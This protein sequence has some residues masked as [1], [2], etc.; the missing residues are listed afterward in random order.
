MSVEEAIKILTNLDVFKCD[1][2]NCK[3]YND[4]N[5]NKYCPDCP[6]RKY[7]EALKILITSYYKLFF[8]YNKED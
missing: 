8:M 6:M 3:Y 7:D 5:A 2:K 1:D 4:C